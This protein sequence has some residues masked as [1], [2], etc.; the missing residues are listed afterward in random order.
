[1][2]DAIVERL[3]NEIRRALTAP[4]LRDSFL[5]AGSEPVG[6]SR[7]DFAKILRDDIRRYAEIVRAAKIEPQ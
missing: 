3:H 7:E 2:P 5:A 6:D 4:Q 1:M